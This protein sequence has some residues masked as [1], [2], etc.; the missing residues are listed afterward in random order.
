M[1][2]KEELTRLSMVAKA[3]DL[4]IDSMLKVNQKQQEDIQELREAVS[5]LIDIVSEMNK[6]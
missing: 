5:L 4:Q 6:D 1:T 2:D 3:Q